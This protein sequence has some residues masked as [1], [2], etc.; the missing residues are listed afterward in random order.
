MNN[1]QPF[2]S[3]ENSYL[4]SCVSFLLSSLVSCSVAFATPKAQAITSEYDFGSV[5]Q[6]SKVNTEFSVKNNG[7]SDL[8]IQK[9]VAGC[10]CTV[11]NASTTPIA[12]GQ[13]GKVSVSFD[14]TGF[15]GSKTK[16]V[17]VYTN[18]SEAQMIVFTLKGTILS[19]F[20]VKPKILEFGEVT[21]ALLDEKNVKSVEI[22]PL[23]PSA[24]T[25]A[26]IKSLSANVEI[27]NSELTA[28]G[29]MLA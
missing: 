29:G 11:A 10:G 7:T 16:D 9:V 24:G 23:K 22:T 1:M 12:P 6:G 28:K 26:L 5:E 4:S 2:A 15:E 3:K 13:I 8:T 17:R 19:D 14:T 18:D 27:V 21:K 25:V 20:E